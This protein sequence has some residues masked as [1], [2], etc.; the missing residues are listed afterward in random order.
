MMQL[1][2]VWGVQSTGRMPQLHCTRHPV[3]HSESMFRAHAA[4]LW[5]GNSP[6]FDELLP[7]LWRCELLIDCCVESH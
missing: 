7:S 2:G 3:P 6:L 5:P 4:C 1:Q